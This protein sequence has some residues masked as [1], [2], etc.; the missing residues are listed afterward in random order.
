[1]TE[2]YQVL[3]REYEY[4]KEFGYTGTHDDYVRF[5]YT[6]Y[7]H[8]MARLSISPMSWFLWLQT[9]KKDKD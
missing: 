1:M 2:A 3:N 8:T 6:R 9:Q 4:A 7:C 5:N